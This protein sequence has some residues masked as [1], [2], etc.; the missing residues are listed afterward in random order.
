MSNSTAEMG[1]KDLN[2]FVTCD[3][4]FCSANMTTL[5]IKWLK[6]NSNYIGLILHYSVKFNVNSFLYCR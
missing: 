3:F 4:L 1:D 5:K 6:L 2:G